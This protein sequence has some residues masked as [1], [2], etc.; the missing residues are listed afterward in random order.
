[1]TAPARGV[2]RPASTDRGDG[3]RRWVGWVA[4]PVVLAVVCLVLWLYV[5]SQTLDS[6][7]ARSLNAATIRETLLRH[8][9]LTAVS[10]V[11]VVLIAVPLGIVLTRPFTRRVRGALLT[12]AN[13]GQ[14]VPTIGLLAL[15]A[16]VFFFLGF[17]AAVVGLVVYAVLPVLRNTMVGLEEVDDAVLEA[18]RGM[19]LSQAQVLRRLELPLAVPVILAGIRTALVI[20]VGTATLAAYIN[21]GGLGTLIVAGFSTNRILVSLTGAILSA[22]LALLVDHLAGIAE[23]LLKP[24]GL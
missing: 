14:A 5:S 6:I 17:W 12:V 4:L 3:Q 7:E 16:V 21:G 19:G 9:A 24:K 15:L 20:N 1:M 10:T 23:D 22:V 2:T 11:L 13:I 8:V 18:G